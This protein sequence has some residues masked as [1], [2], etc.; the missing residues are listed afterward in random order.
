MPSVIVVAVEAAVSVCKAP[1][2]PVPEV[3]VVIV[4]LAHPFVPVNVNGPTPPL[5]IFVS[6]T[7]GSFVLVNV[8]AMFEPGAVAA[9]S[10][11][12]A[13]VA[14]LGTAVPPEPKP[15]QVAEART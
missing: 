2:T 8:H 15:V 9:A 10:S 7:V 5:L 12:N 11:A 14:R 6:V 4:W 13:P 3:T 1:A